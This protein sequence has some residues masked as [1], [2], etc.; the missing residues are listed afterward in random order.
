MAANGRN[1][2]SRRGET[3]DA[4]ERGKDYLTPDRGRAAARGGEEGPPRRPRLTPC[5]WSSY[6]HG[7]RVSEAT[8][9]AGSS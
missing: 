2:K 8:A 5:S 3:V 9:C 4:H 7:L 6:R 1:V